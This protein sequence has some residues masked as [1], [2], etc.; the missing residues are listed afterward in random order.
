MPLIHQPTE[1]EP[2]SGKDTIL[3]NIHVERLL[4]TSESEGSMYA[5]KRWGL[6]LANAEASAEGRGIYVWKGFVYAIIGNTVYKDGTSIGTLSSST[7]RVS[8]DQAFDGSGLLVINDGNNTLYT[9]DTA[10]TITAL[11]DPQLPS[12]ILHG[13]V[14]LDQYAFIMDNQGN[15]HNS[16]IGDVSSWLGDS[17]NTEVRSDDGVAIARYVNY[18]VAFNTDTIDMFYDAAHA[19]GSPLSRF[20]GMVSLVGCASAKSVVNCGQHLYF[21]ARETKG[22]G[23]FIGG[24]RGGFEVE[25]VS[26]T[27]LEEILDK[28]GANLDDAYAYYLAKGGKKFYV[29]TL[30]TTAQRTFVFDIDLELWYEWTSDVSDTESF[31]S[32]TD[33]ADEEGSLYCL[34]ATNGDYYTMEPE[35]YQDAGETIKV[36][37]ITRKL[38]FDTFQ[39][40]F[41]WRLAPVGDRTAT[42]ATLNISYTDDDY[43]TWHANRPVDLSDYEAFLTRLGMFKSRAFR[44]QFQSNHPLRLSHLENN[45]DTGHYARGR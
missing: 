13:I 33:A 17:I 3:K 22:G 14:V 39:N 32:I 23:R 16:E 28:E 38:D 4:E 41:H 18:V 29:V 35:T 40:K 2:G 12:T 19:T 20:E 8:F 21:I 6:T 34:H 37:V 25:R 5:V 1:R 44:L 24:M 42:A 30:P 7:G 36:E 11:T 9:I 15:V 27:A 43:Q 26:T 45:I 10:D 31:F